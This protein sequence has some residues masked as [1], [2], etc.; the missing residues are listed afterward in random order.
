M[1]HNKNADTLLFLL[2]I[3]KYQRKKILKE[4]SLWVQKV[5]KGENERFLGL[6]YRNIYWI[7]KINFQ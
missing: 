5:K 2:S 7:Q 3:T 6:L 4:H 1:K